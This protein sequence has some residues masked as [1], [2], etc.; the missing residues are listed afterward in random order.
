MVKIGMDFGTTYSMLSHVVKDSVTGQDR[1]T[2]LSL[3]ADE[4]E[5]S[6]VVKSIIVKM[7]NEELQFGEAAYEEKNEPGVVTFIGFKMMMTETSPQRLAEKK[8][9]NKLTPGYLSEQFILNYISAYLDQT[10]ENEVEKLI[11]GV[12]NIWFEKPELYD[13][14]GKLIEG[15]ASHSDMIK[16]VDLIKEPE[17]AAAYFID[18]YYKMKN[19]HYTGYVLMIDYGGGTLDIALCEVKHNNERPD[20]SVKYY[21]GAGENQEGFIGNAGLA[22][23]EK[24]VCLAAATDEI[25]EDDVK[26]KLSFSNAIYKLE[27]KI[28]TGDKKIQEAL[29]D[30]LADRKG[31]TKQFDSFLMEGRQIKVTFGMLAQA[32]GDV[33]EA[34]LVDRLEI[35]KDY[36]LAHNIDYS[37]DADNFKIVPVG[38]FC[39]FFLTRETI[40]E[41]FSQELGILAGEDKRFEEIIT[42]SDYEKAI[43]YGAALIANEIV[44]IR[45]TAPYSIG[46]VEPITVNR[47]K[48][49]RLHFVIKYGEDIKQNEPVYYSKPFIAGPNAILTLCFQ[50]SGDGPRSRET[51]PEFFDRLKIKS[52]FCRLGFSFDNSSVLT[53]HKAYFANPKDAVNFANQLDESKDRLAYILDVVGDGLYAVEDEE[54]V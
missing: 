20:I 38:G 22:F 45:P 5:L 28:I 10:S 30:R 15:I 26:L 6:H 7:P 12:P 33:I 14:R 13:V 52:G 11:I 25:S 46:I 19:S 21:T 3:G 31:N 9:G 39:K 2:G 54:Y 29:K 4:N 32:Y 40:M 49:K 35:M 24:V 1:V 50:F 18:K 48:K 37:P 16:N 43:S 34:I 44:D 36:M 23:L 8:Y 51:K 41:A 42:G 27:R 17:A 53:I 47:E